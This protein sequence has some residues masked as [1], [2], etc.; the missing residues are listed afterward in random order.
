M[1]N[2]KKSIF[3]LFLFSFNLT[4]IFTMES[5]DG[6]APMDQVENE[7]KIGVKRD[8]DVDSGS[9]DGENEV[10]LV[11][12]RRG[13]VSAA[14]A[15]TAAL[16]PTTSV[17]A[18][19]PTTTTSDIPVVLSTITRRF[20]GGGLLTHDQDQERDQ[21]QEDGFGLDFF[22]ENTF[23]QN[24]SLLSP[25]LLQGSG[26]SLVSNVPTVVSPLTIAPAAITTVAATTSI[27]PTTIT[28]PELVSN[29]DCELN[30]S[31][32]L[33]LNKIADKFAQS[34]LIII[35][36]IN[37]V[38]R[39]LRGKSEL[40]KIKYLKLFFAQNFYNLN[41]F[42][43]CCLN[44]KNGDDKRKK[45]GDNLS[46][47]L[48]SLL[49]Y[50]KL[51]ED[52]INTVKNQID[53]CV[54]YYISLL[55]PGRYAGFFNKF[56]SGL[57]YYGIYKPV[58]F[59][60][61][62]MYGLG[63]WLRNVSFNHNSLSQRAYLRNCLEIELVKSVSNKI[64][65]TI[66]RNVKKSRFNGCVYVEQQ[67]LGLFSYLND[68]PTKTVFE[69]KLANHVKSCFVE[70]FNPLLFNSDEKLD[71][72]VEKL[73]TSAKANENFPA[74]LMKKLKEDKSLH[75]DLKVFLGE[76]PN[77][78]QDISD[79]FIYQINEY[80]I[81]MNKTRFLLLKCLPA[82]ALNITAG[83]TIWDLYKNFSTYAKN[84]VVST[85]FKFVG[86]LLFIDYLYE[87][88]VLNKLCGIKVATP[89]AKVINWG[90]S[91]LFFWKK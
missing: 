12:R 14:L 8:R 27:T 57:G 10:R 51:P 81:L 17:T 82:I 53:K 88:L 2:F 60:L 91:K 3:F 67:E 20:P 35:S 80:K 21:I 46:T 34:F 49:D 55:K 40:E 77:V 58:K 5:E 62:P 13:T 75:L 29:L 83:M 33:K 78:I 9:D 42:R 11:R 44:L 7:R 45:I 56:F 72:F 76:C 74:L 85:S 22:E 43:L 70:I 79:V 32:Q 54:S 41:D 6:S 26:D 1:K 84:N 61:S 64:L 19:T 38:D 23:D 24:A 4:N 50:S 86:F 31:E 15:R 71:K 69:Q 36:R 68:E 28:A 73:L 90:I 18:S 47:Q 89:P 66:T 16:L 59:C 30:Y 52:Q 48:K 63:K 37:F 25:E 65:L 87:F 39:N